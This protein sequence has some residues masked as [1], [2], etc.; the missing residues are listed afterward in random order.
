MMRRHK[1]L[2]AHLLYAIASS[3]KHRNRRNREEII[4]LHPASIYHVSHDGQ[5]ILHVTV[6]HRQKKIYKP[7]KKYGVL[8][9]L[10]VGISS[11]GCTL[12]HQ[13]AKIDFYQPGDQA[14]VVFR[15]RDELHWFQ[16]VLSDLW[17]YASTEDNSWWCRL[18]RNDDNITAREMF[19]QEHSAML[20]EAT[21]WIKQTAQSCSTVVVL[22]ATV[23]FA[24][25]YT[26][27]GGNKD[28]SPILRNSLVF[29][30][31]YTA[32]AIALASSLLSVMMFLSI[33]TSPFRMQDLYEDL[34][35][36]LADG[37]GWMLVSLMTTMLTFGST[38]LLT[39]GQKKMNWISFWVYFVMVLPFIISGLTQYP[40]MTIKYRL[41]IIGQLLLDLY[42]E[43]DNG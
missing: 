3:S 21:D 34:P 22:I 13:A 14:G 35:L 31:F 28:G 38:I 15:L 43:E 2:K 24:A 7:L 20:K 26:V 29:R 12:L 33:L 10:A 42:L 1:L 39:V 25:M 16:R 40:I 8:R 6:K 32:D 37:F 5:N 36:N 23:V 18:Y 41:K 19:E 4:D 30:F 27:P 11:G 17:I 9:S